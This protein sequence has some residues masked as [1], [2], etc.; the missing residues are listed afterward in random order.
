VKVPEQEQAQVDDEPKEQE[1]ARSSKAAQA[2]QVNLSAKLTKD[3]KDAKRAE[4]AEIV[5]LIKIAR[6]EL[7]TLMIAVGF[8]VISSAVSM[9]VPA[10]IGRVLDIASGKTELPFG[11]DIPTFYLILASVFTIGAAANYGRVILLRIVGERIVTKLRSQLF[12]NT[13]TQ[14]AEFF[15]A[16]RTG[17]L[18]SRLGSDT[19]IVGK[20]ITQNLSDGLRSFI[21]GVVGFGLMGYLSG[22]LTGVLCIAFPPVAVMAYFYG[23]AVRTL[24]K[25]IQENLGTLTKIGE[26]RLGAVRTSQSF[27][28]EVQEVHRYNTQARKIFDLGKKDAYLS[29][30]FFSVSGWAGNIIMIAV[31]YVGGGLVQSGAM[32]P[33]ELTSFLMYTAFTGGSIFGLS[34]FYSELMKGAG[35]AGRLFELQDRRPTISPT[36][37]NPVSD[38]QG[39]IVFDKLSFSYPTRPAVKIFEDLSFQIEQGTN[40]AIVAPSGAGKSTVASLLLRFYSPSSGSITI[41]G[42]DITTMNVKQL[43]RRIGYVGQEPVLFSGSIA[44]NICYGRPNA[45]RSAILHA[46]KRANCNFI[47]DFPEGLDTPV[48]P[49]GTQLSGGQKQ[50]IAIARALLKDPDILILDEATSALVS[51]DNTEVSSR[52]NH[53]HQD[54][55]SETLVNEALSTLLRGNNTTISIAHRL[56]TIKRSDLIICIGSDGRVAEVG[57]YAA[58]SANRQGAFSKLME[59]QISGGDAPSR[60]V[61]EEPKP[62]LHDPADEEESW[63]DEKEPKAEGEMTEVPV[64]EMKGTETAEERKAS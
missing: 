33:G 63:R 42:K 3:G 53:P 35:A 25:K 41:N 58:L 43:R 15:D 50:R 54:A 21:S 38:L 64:K 37:G 14:D 24:S 20:A 4:W 44:E 51:F 34:G 1:F 61:K 9:S 40:V 7:R 60:P 12:R 46:A 22:K 17:D 2:T 16:N 19:V 29:A 36:I 11:I 47:G 32:T 18:I 6:P 59:W 49:R 48:G 31:L 27:S 13:I 56:S 5:R 23:R 57:S 39:K 45:S 26:E 8:L 62:E 30:T 10:L 28:G 55:E 52:T